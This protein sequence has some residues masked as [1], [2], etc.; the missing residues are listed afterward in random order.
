MVKK[1][2]A[3]HLLYARCLLVLELK[4]FFHFIHQ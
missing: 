3:L 1:E 2:L 4:R